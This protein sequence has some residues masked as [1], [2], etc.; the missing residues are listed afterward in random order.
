MNAIADTLETPALSHAIRTVLLVEDDPSQARIVGRWLSRAGLEVTHA[1]N[2]ISAIGHTEDRRWDLVI[3]DIDLPDGSGLDLARRLKSTNAAQRVLLATAFASVDLAVNALRARVDDFMV[4]PL[5]RNA[6]YEK[7]AELSQTMEPELARSPS[8]RVLAIGAHPDDIEIG[9]GGL[10]ARHVAMGD[11]VV[12]LT[13]TG[14]E[15][16][17]SASER[18][19]EA[20]HAAES[21]GARLVMADLPDTAISEGGLTIETIERAVA[22]HQPTIVYTHTPNDMHQDHR[23]TYRATMV[24]ARGVPNIFCYQSPSTTTDFKPTQFVDVSEYL[25]NKLEA[26]SRHN[27]QGNRTY[28]EPDLV[29]ATARYW[30]RFA[31]YREVEPLEVVRTSA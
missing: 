23:N 26:I 5:N 25:D 9:V 15:R 10:L 31:G 21:L 1:E 4:K 12:I 7:I 20:K 18:G 22:I 30:G 13:L 6:L 29:R 16:G 27:S 11:E 2:I 14:G 3:C 24:A 17:G 28:L 8:R 19:V